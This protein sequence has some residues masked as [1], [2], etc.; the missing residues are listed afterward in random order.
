MEI[1][2]KMCAVFRS[3][4]N[5]RYLI[6]LQKYVFNFIIINSGY[7]PINCLYPEDNDP[8]IAIAHFCVSNS[9]STISSSSHFR[10]ISA[11]HKVSST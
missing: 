5:R 1:V 4:T 11:F 8:Y 2:V 7:N 9:K 6:Q 3:K 10:Y